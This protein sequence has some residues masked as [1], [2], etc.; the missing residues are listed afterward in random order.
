MRFLYSLLIILLFINATYSRDY[1]Q[2]EEIIK[3]ILEESDPPGGNVVEK[4]EKKNERKENKFTAPSVSE[5]LLKSGIQFYES[6]QYDHALAKFREVYHLSAGQYSD[7]AKIWAG[8][9][10]LRKHKYED[11]VSE[12]ISIGDS[13]GEFPTA[14]YYTG[15]CYL[16]LGNTDRAVDYLYRMSVRFP[17]HELADDA[18]LHAGKLYLRKRR[19]EDAMNVSV[20][21]IKRYKDRETIDDAYYLLAKI[22]EKDS[23]LQDAETAR[24]IYRVFLK[25]HNKGVSFF[26][27]SPLVGRVKKDLF[28]LEKIFFKTT[29]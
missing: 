29:D 12:F 7:T 3:G 24:R 11:A 21:I 22:F 6:G 1:R 19:G 26:A 17:E 25:K 9:T 2:T 27:K 8:K 20:M 5:S 4:D 28:N 16:R 14:Q 23:L 10:L 18:L 13:S 15:I